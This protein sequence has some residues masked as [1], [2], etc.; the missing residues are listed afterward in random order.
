MIYDAKIIGVET[1]SDNVLYKMRIINSQTL[2]YREIR[3]RYGFLSELHSQLQD[4][5]Q[6]YQ[7]PQFPKKEFLYSIFRENAFIKQSEQMIAEYLSQLIKAPPPICKPLLEFLREGVDAVRQKEL[8]REISSKSELLK[9]IKPEKVL[10]K[11]CFGKT[12]LCS[13]QGKKVIL[14][15]FYVL[16]HQSEQFFGHYFD[17]HLYFTDFTFICKVIHIFFLHQ[18]LNFMDS[19]FGSTKQ[20]RSCKSQH[21]AHFF[22]SQ[23][24][25]DVVKLHSIEVYEGQNLE[26]IIKEKRIK[27]TPFTNIELG[28]LIQKLLD[29][30]VFLHNNQ[31][32]GNRVTATS[33]IINQDNL[34]LT[35]IQE[36]NERYKDKYLIDGLAFRTEQEYDTI[37]F[38]PEKLNQTQ[39]NSKMADTWQFG[40]CIVKAALLCTNRE[41]EGIHQPNIVHDLI[42]EIK[43]QYGDEIANILML[44]L[45]NSIQQRASIKD[46]HSLASQSSVIPFQKLFLNQN[47]DPPITF[48]RLNSLNNEEQQRLTDQLSKST[49]LS[50][51]I[52]LYDQ[53]VDNKEFDKL[54][55]LLGDFAIIRDIEIILNKTRKANVSSILSSLASIKSLINL[56]LDLKGLEIDQND[57]IY[58]ISILKQMTMMQRFTLDCSSMDFINFLRAELDEKTK[59]IF[60]HESQ[61]I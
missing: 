29:A 18:K 25:Q 13:L 30:L 53:E 47:Q 41:L 4:L 17:T 26:E 59:M 2:E 44:S 36:P 15:K 5:N 28:N 40:V 27:K 12:T 21:F 34:K 31:C 19:M 35:G 45:K 32:Y 20:P 9:L 52:N 23:Y 16:R 42:S 55:Q 33:I 60:Y 50:I 51:K 8:S 7:L 22:S 10:K 57:I 3:V 24:K 14:H 39:Y 46:L 61:L 38:P 49:M 37:Y 48:I 54:M 11:S 56:N 58:G 43:S 6:D 1:H